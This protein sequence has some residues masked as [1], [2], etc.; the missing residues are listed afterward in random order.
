MLGTALWNQ[1][2]Y[3]G[4]FWLINYPFYFVI[5]L[6]L[7]HLGYSNEELT[8]TK[9]NN[10]LMKP[11]HL[12]QIYHIVYRDCVNNCVFFPSFIMGTDLSYSREYH[13]FFLSSPLTFPFLL[14]PPFSTPSSIIF[15]S[16]FFLFYYFFGIILLHT[17]MYEL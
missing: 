16:L 9:L 13:F 11:H 12:I 6:K 3:L 17:Y 8:D 14:N 5:F 7:A 1:I 4:M 2:C 10:F 15:L